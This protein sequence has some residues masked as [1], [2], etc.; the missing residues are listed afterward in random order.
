MQNYNTIIGVISMREKGFSTRDC[1][2]R[3]GLGSS[4]VTLIMKR[5]SELGLSL[6]DLKTMDTDKVE[7][8]FFP[9]ESSRRSEIPLPDYDAIYQ[10][11]NAK[12][13][14]ANLFFLWKEYKKEH[15]NG[16]QYTQFVEH[17]N[18]YVKEKYGVVDVSMAVNRVPGERMYIDWVGDQPELIVNRDTGE[19]SK[20]HVFVTTVGVSS[21]IYAELFP[22]EK[23]SNFV[24]GTVNAI[25]YYGAV[26][27]YFVPDNAKTAVTKHTKDELLINAAYQD[28]ESFYDV[29]VLPPPAR[30]PKGKPTV[31]RYVQYLETELLEKLKENVYYSFEEA[32]RVTKEIVAAIN[33]ERPDGWD[34]THNEAFENYDRPQMKTL[35]DG[36][37]SPC[38]YVVFSSVP[39]NYHLLFDD[40]Y[41]SVFYTYYQKPV[42]LKATMTEIIISDENNRFICRHSRSY[43]KFPKYITKDE[44]MPASHRFY[45]EVNERDGDYYRRWAAAIGAEMA[46]MIDRILKSYK[47]EE[48]AYNSCNGI[49]HMCDNQSKVLCNEAALRCI[50]LNTC[51]YTYFK[52]ILTEV[53]N[54]DGRTNNS[55]PTHD[56]IWGK[57]YYR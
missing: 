52:K 26:A 47:H 50:Q 19:L 37:F 4:T 35:S 27:R 23:Q 15:P 14:K 43:T 17:Y 13:S 10:R 56:N 16:Y 7:K 30:K 40:H 49:L 39:R 33:D 12:G 21:K 25:N 3:F 34:L 20:I 44:H 55:L 36:S 5:Y 1:R 24:R 9:P 6:T 22:N 45:K 42:I 11:K 46:V 53:L 31:E 28:L 57:E 29:V 48:Q 51:K 41:Y 54:S 18:R 38:E 8:I 32:N 2:A